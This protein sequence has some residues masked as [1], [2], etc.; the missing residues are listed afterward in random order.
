MSPE[1]SG[2]LLALHDEKLVVGAVERVETVNARQVVVVRQHQEL[3]AML[4][5]PRDHVVRRRVA[6][7]VERVRMEIAFVPAHSVAGLRM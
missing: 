2:D 1:P 7:A 3:I 5:V 6:V 4:P